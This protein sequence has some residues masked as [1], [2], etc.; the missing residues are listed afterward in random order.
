MYLDLYWTLLLL[1]LS[2][3]SRVRLC[4]TPETAAHQAPP[5]LGFSRQERWTLLLL[6]LSHFSRVRLC[7]TPETAAHQ[8]PLSLGFSRQEHWSGLPFPSPVALNYDPCLH[9][10]EKTHN[11]KPHTDQ[12]NVLYF[13][14]DRVHIN[15]LFFTNLCTKHLYYV[16]N[17]KKC[18]IFCFGSEQNLVVSKISFIS[19]KSK[20][21]E[22][23]IKTVP[24]F[25]ILVICAFPN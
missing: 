4:A 15:L 25:N 14:L 9:Q 22:V 5:S 24:R 13:K 1:L 20:D 18:L 8:A 21:F 10:V 19:S 7:A 3:F 16:Y 11:T 6:L 17:K 23:F 12:D 2:R